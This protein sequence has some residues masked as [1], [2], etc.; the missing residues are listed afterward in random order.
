MLAFLRT[1]ALNRG[2]LGGSRMWVG[3]GA[4][5]WT[6]R[7]FQWLTRAETTVIYRDKLDPGQAV[8]IRHQPPGPTRR[9]AKKSAKRVRKDAKQA[10]RATRKASRRGSEMSAHQSAAAD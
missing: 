10:K 3:V 9:Q 2:L 8:V 4:L 6:I 7:L 5:V 1:R